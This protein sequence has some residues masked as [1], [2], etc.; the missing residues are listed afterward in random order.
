MAFAHGKTGAF[1]LGTTGTPGTVVD[2][3]AWLDNVS[4]PESVDTGETTVF[5]QSSKSY[6]VGLKDSTISISGKWDATTL[7][8]Q[9]FGLLGSTVAVT[10]EY[11]PAGST[12]GM[13]RYTGTA[14]MTSYQVTTPV[15]DVV[16]F[17]CDFQVTGNV[18]R[19]T[20]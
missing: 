12:V 13:V 6:V 17:S 3:S 19:N 8:P 14:F 1:K 10:W 4:F 2:L 15:A 5:G 16:T 9:L 18:T 11:G 7:D 20:F